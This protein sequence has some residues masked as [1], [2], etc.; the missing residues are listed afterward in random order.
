MPPESPPPRHLRRR[1]LKRSDLSGRSVTEERL[2]VDMV[3]QIQS[4]CPCVWCVKSFGEDIS[5]HGGRRSVE[6][7][8]PC[9]LENLVQPM[10]VNA[11]GST[12]MPHVRVLASPANLNHCCVVLV[13]EANH[14]TLENFVPKGQTWHSNCSHRKVSCHDFRF[15]RTVAHGCLF[16]R[17]GLNRKERIRTTHAQKRA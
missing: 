2:G 12:H 13:E 6:Q 15:R 10:D 5:A 1:R 8:H 16:S 7:V 14:V 17:D 4:V 11:M 9:F 3:Y